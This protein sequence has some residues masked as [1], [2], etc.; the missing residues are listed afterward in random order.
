MLCG[1]VTFKANFNFLELPVES[2]FEKVGTATIQAEKVL[3]EGMEVK[4]SSRR[5]TLNVSQFVKSKNLVLCELG[6]WAIS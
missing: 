6:S 3:M 2:F 4:V 1:T 5:F